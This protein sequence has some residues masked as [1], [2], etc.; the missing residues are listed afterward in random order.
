MDMD[1]NKRS[2]E[3][4]QST[5]EFLASFVF[6]FTFMVILIRFAL[7]AA[8][9]YMVHY[10]TFMA[11]RAYLV[12]DHNINS[13]DGADAPAFGVAKKVFD[14][15]RLGNFMGG[16]PPILKVNHPD[17]GGRSAFVGV[18]ADFEQMFSI[19][20]LFGGGAPLKLRS[21]SFLGRE[22]TRATCAER[23][24]RAMRDAGGVCDKNSTFFDNG[25]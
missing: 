7:S 15:F 14:D 21:E 20:K 5:V 16:E 10:A 23:V 9:G 13:P 22:P 4:G 17:F 24:C 12:Y 18:Y 2:L 19:P 8:N 11:S 25:C 6:V 3:K 1:G